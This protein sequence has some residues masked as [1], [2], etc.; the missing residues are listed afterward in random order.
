MTKNQSAPWQLSN[1]ESVANQF[2]R[3]G[4][5]G[6]WLQIVLLVVPIFLLFY[7]L[8]SNNPGGSA[9]KGLDLGDYLSYGSLIV[10]VFTTIWFYLYTRLAKQIV[11]PN[12]RPSQASVQRRIWI[13]LWASCVGI[14]FSMI[15][16]MGTVGRLLI[17][18]MATPQS[19]L[20]VAQAGSD[21]A[22]TVSAI[23]AVSLMSL[24]LILS[25]EIAILVISIW[26]LFRVTRQ[27][28]ETAQAGAAV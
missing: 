8:L 10:M 17:T 4:W 5:I 22:Y 16:M 23:N 3:L 27:P 6:F 2:S 19:G 11:D 24:Q 20:Q 12:T 7:V 28:K 26:L 21:P 1:P 25:A 13:G 15:L 18:L 9:R 14:V